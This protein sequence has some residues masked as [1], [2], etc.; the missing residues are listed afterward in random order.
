MSRYIPLVIIAVIILQFVFSGEDIT[1]ER[2]LTYNPKNILAAAMFIIALYVIK[3][4]VLP[5]PITLAKLAAGYFLPFALA[6]VINMLGILLSYSIPYFISRYYGKGFI[7]RLE[8]KGWMKKWLAIQDD[9]VFFASFLLRSIPFFMESYVSIYA[10]VKRLPFHE[11]IVGSL[12]GSITH[13]VTLT[14]IGGH[15]TDFMTPL[16]AVLISLNLLQIFICFWR[17]KVM[18]ERVQ[19]VN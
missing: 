5:F 13:I 8:D 16:F 6:L 12:L 2:L 1:L 11:F 15:L 9:Q 17:V 4:V 7:A 18:R 10:G 19:E 3:G 14:Y